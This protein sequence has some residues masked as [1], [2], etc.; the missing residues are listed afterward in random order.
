MVTPVRLHFL[1]AVEKIFK[2]LHHKHVMKEDTSNNSLLVKDEKLDSQIL[3]IKKQ[4][5]KLCP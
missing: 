5:Q 2:R 3:R 4:N 1:F